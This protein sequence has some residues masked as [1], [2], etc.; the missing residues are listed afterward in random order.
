MAGGALSF[1]Q[2]DVTRGARAMPGQQVT[3]VEGR[4]GRR[5]T[6][7]DGDDAVGIAAAM[8]QP[9]HWQLSRGRTR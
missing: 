2:T 4:S 9:E 3:R 5:V 7:G 8:A 6:A 1:H